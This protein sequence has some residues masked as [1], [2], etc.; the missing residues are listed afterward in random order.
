LLLGTK[1]VQGLGI[2]TEVK[3]TA[4]L[5]HA[6]YDSDEEDERTPAE[7]REVAKHDKYE[8]SLQQK[9]EVREMRVYLISVM[10]ENFVALNT[11]D[12]LSVA[13][14]TLPS[15]KTLSNIRKSIDEQILTKITIFDF[16]HGYAIDVET[17]LRELIRIRDWYGLAEILLCIMGDG[18][19]ISRTNKTVILAF[20]VLNEGRLHAFRSHNLYNFLRLP[21]LLP[22]LLY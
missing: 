14:P 9:A 4:E 12:N 22:H 17:F 15:A 8:L 3:L 13:I 19:T 16:P 7:R 18:R 1:I 11:I 21:L 5:L 20:T 6:A 2:D 10:D